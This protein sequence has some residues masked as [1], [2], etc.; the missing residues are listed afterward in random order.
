MQPA[1]P[2]YVN[3]PVPVE[4]L[5]QTQP[6]TYTV[7][8]SPAN[9]KYPTEA[10]S[11]PQQPFYQPPKSMPSYIPIYV[12]ADRSGFPQFPQQAFTTAPAM[13]MPIQP[14]LMTS[15]NVPMTDLVYVPGE[16]KNHFIQFINLLF[17]N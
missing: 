6:V 13:G 5:N 3:F 16:M 11:Q 14:D 15:P 17:A 12:Q 9:A 7:T 8:I 2:G 1:P 4:L 10:P